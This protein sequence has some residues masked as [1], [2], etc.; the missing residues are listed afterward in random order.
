MSTCALC[1]P[2]VRPKSRAG[3]ANPAAPSAP[4]P[5]GNFGSLEGRRGAQRV[6]QHLG[7]GLAAQAPISSPHLRGE[8]E[9][10]RSPRA[11]P[12]RGPAGVG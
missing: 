9:D 6:P 12:G 4:P 8:A 5:P 2:G 10:A 11:P 1:A 7:Q 3:A